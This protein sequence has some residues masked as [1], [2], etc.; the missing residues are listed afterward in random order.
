MH[1]VR[2]SKFSTLIR[3]NEIDPNLIS[4]CTATFQR[5]S[6]TTITYES[7]EAVNQA[8]D[9]DVVPLHTQLFSHQYKT[10]EQLYDLERDILK[11]ILCPL[12]TK[13]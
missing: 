6:S 2:A 12:Y 9:L 5:R 8:E 1:E 7:A 13:I 11:K 4:R 3:S 10:K